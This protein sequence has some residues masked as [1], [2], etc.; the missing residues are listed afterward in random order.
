MKEIQ[1]RLGQDR[2][3]D[4]LCRKVRF[5]TRCARMEESSRVLSRAAGSLSAH[6]MFIG[7]APGRLGAD[8]SEIPFHGDM[9]GHNFEELISF[10]GLDRSDMF[11]TN[12]VLCNPRSESGT[13]AT[14]NKEEQTNCSGHLIEQIQT[15]Q[16]ALVVTLGAFALEATELVE[17]HG[18]KLSADV[19]TVHPWFGRHLIPLYHPGARALI[20]RSMANQRSDY[21]FVA[22]RVRRSTGQPRRPSSG[23][24]RKEVV[25]FA[26]AL[27]VEAGP[28]SYFAL[29]KLLY[30][31]ECEAWRTWGRTATGGF[32]LR[33][34][35]GPYCTD[36][37]LAKLR[38]ALPELEVRGV[39]QKIVL[40][41]QRSVLTAEGVAPLQDPEAALLKTVLTD[42]AGMSDSELKTKVYMSTPMRRILRR[43]RAQLVNMYNAPIQFF[44]A[45]AARKA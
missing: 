21:Q 22:D 38:R 33:Q 5:C 1:L 19:R 40:R 15:I 6:V 34:K 30:L 11:V 18:L 12:A 8:A 44:G 31:V 45:E 23:R 3:F 36:L 39:A 32:F 2:Q 26:S 7:E 28:V 16:P 24:T 10:A 43:E 25:R 4:E 13:N 37:H 29:H 41:L 27:L 35:D 20:H 9:A 42:T 17:P 14:P